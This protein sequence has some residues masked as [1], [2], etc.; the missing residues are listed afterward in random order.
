MALTEQATMM[1]T[2]ETSDNDKGKKKKAG[3]KEKKTTTSTA[4]TTMAAPATG[5]IGEAA[6]KKAEE[7]PSKTI[8]TL[9]EYF[10]N[11]M[12]N[13]RAGEKFVDAAVFSAPGRSQYGAVATK[14]GPTYAE[15][16]I[17]GNVVNPKD[18]LVS[19]RYNKGVAEVFDKLEKYGVGANEQQALTQLTSMFKEENRKYNLGE[20]SIFNDPAYR[21]LG[22]M[23]RGAGETYEQDLVKK[24]AS[25][26]AKLKKQRDEQY[27]VS[28]ASTSEAA[29]KI[30][31]S[32]TVNVVGK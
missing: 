13:T 32:A 5:A 12:G 27:G 9:S 24:L 29:K 10:T 4:A 2:T 17:S 1:A 22:G 16:D 20:N 19:A 8:P 31:P 3:I 7:K 11:S 28:G 26:Y 15:L 30:T 6:L 18:G 23:G 25:G 21:S 14:D